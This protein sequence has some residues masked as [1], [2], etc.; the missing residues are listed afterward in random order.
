MPTLSVVGAQ[1]GDEGKGK[2]VHYLSERADWIVRYQGGNNAGHTVLHGNK[3]LAFHLVPSGL[4][5]PGKKG[6]IGHG[7][8][9]DPAALK[10]EVEFLGR[11]GVRLAGRLYLSLGTHVVFP[12][13]LRLDAHQE[14]AGGIGTT[15]RGI[16]PCYVDKAARVGIRLAEYL[17]SDFPHWLDRALERR[18]AELKTLGQPIHELRK[19]ALASRAGLLRWVKPFCADTVV[20]LHE[21]LARK[22]SILFEGAQGVM[23]DLDFGTYPFV[24]SSHPSAG[25]VCV[26]A[27]VGPGAIDDVLGVAKAYTTRIG[28]GPFP[29]EM[30]APLAERLREKGKEYGATTGRPRRIGWLDLV[31][32]RYAARVS[33]IRTLAMTKLDTLSGIGPIKVCV[34]YRYKGRLLKD[35]PAACSAQEEARPVY[36]EL[37]GFEGELSDIRSFS[38]LPASCKSYV[39]WVERK[40]GVPVSIVSVGQSREATIL[41]DRNLFR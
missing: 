24:T 1:W 5:F 7:V 21:A 37:P 39:R 34:G 26:G 13:H 14:S 27:G 6:I 38:K 23:L 19:A 30:E 18:S 9:V 28:A 32:L 16:G 4:L 29:T 3:L 35:F 25:G 41:R 11:Q 8:V 31:Q 20:L 12:Y 40:L 10:E 15:R 17:D 22:E 33:G 36:E 2:I